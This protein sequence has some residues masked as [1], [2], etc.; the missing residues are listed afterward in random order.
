MWKPQQSVYTKFGDFMT[1]N[2]VRNPAL[3]AKITKLWLLVCPMSS[4]LE[5]S[6]GAQHRC[7]ANDE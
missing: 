4:G 1:L 3:L 6:R 5:R 2:P 7:V